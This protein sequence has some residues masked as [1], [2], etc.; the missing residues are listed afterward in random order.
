[1]SCYV[2]RLR[3]I[4]PPVIIYVTDSCATLLCN[5]PAGAFASKDVVYRIKYLKAGD[6]V[7]QSTTESTAL[8]QT[9]AG[10]DAN[11]L[12][13]FRVV[14]KYR[15]RRGETRTVESFSA[16][17]KT[18]E[19]NCITK[20]KKKLSYRRET[21]RQLPTW[22]EGGGFGVPAHSPSIP[23]VIP[24]YMVESESHNVRTSSV[25]SVKRTLR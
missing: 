3:N 17:A 19:G 13:L 14:A 25:P 20:G 8:W 12:Y 15:G 24:V 5:P 10:L 9:V 11:W 21:A 23:L 16:L 18:D 4:N 2:V 22:M 7:W 6:N 1:M